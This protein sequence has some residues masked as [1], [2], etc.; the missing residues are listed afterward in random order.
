MSCGLVV[1]RQDHRCAL[2]Q[3]FEMFFN[4]FLVHPEESWLHFLDNISYRPVWCNTCIIGIVGSSYHYSCCNM[5]QS[6]IAGETV[7]TC[8]LLLI[9][10][11]PCPP[12]PCLLLPHFVSSTL[13]LLGASCCCHDDLDAIHHSKQN[14]SVFLGADFLV[15]V[16]WYKLFECFMAQC[17]WYMHR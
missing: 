8:W 10:Q 9:Y 5:V 4:H 3:L 2:L 11:M 1:C 16:P 14:M 12:T 6:H 7:K 15:V 13:V 17:W